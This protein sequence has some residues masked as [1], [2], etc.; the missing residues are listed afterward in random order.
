VP[1]DRKTQGLFLRLPVLFNL[2]FAILDQLKRFAGWISTHA[3][4][5]LV[6]GY[7]DRLWILMASDRVAVENLSGGNQQK[8]LIG[9]WIARDPKVMM[10]CD[11]CRGVDIG[12]K[13]QVHH[14]IR[15]LAAQGK[16]I[17]IFSTELEELVGVADRVIVLFE[18]RIT[19]ELAGEQ[20]NPANLLRLFFGESSGHGIRT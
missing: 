5:K 14:E 18:G 6:K 15:E 17:L 3:E 19:G 7:V 11:P 2:S 20:I 1:E 16:G 4:R 9:K 13:D 10:F 12:A 8:V